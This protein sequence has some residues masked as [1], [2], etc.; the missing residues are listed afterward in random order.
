MSNLNNYNAIVSTDL[1]VAPALSNLLIV[2]VVV[3]LYDSLD[4]LL[5]QDSLL[6]KLNKIGYVVIAPYY[7]D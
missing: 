4:M 3:V 1:Y 7:L 2:K 6:Y 5:L